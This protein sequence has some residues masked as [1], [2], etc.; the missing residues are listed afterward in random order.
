MIKARSEQAV[1]VG[2][3]G[4]EIIVR[5][6][7][8]VGPGDTT[9]RFTYWPVRIARGGEVLVPGRQTDFVQYIDVRD[10]ADWMVA[11]IEG[12]TI[13]TFNVS[14]PAAKQ[15]LLQFVDALRPL[16]TTKL[17]FTWIDDYQWLRKYPLRKRPDGTTT[18]LTFAV[19]WVMSEGDELGHTQISNRKALAAGLKLRPLL[20]TA[21]DTI[22]WRASAA[23]P[24]DLKKQPRYV[25]TPEQEVAMLAA[26]KA[27]KVGG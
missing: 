18:G 1:R 10:L 19:P 13:G 3:P 27:R 26:W 2:V 5:P 17:T 7:Y 16:A 15:T 6:N 12:D 25:L 8:I 23:V 21:R 22:A 20:V 9:D 14:G 11:A 24:D 4:R